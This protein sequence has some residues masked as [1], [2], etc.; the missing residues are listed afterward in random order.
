MAVLSG[1]FDMTEQSERRTPS[2]DECRTFGDES[3]HVD[4]TVNEEGHETEN[5][6]HAEIVSSDE[7]QE[8]GDSEC[9]WIARIE[10]GRVRLLVTT[11]EDDGWAIDQQLT[12]G[13]CAQLANFFFRA[14]VALRLAEVAHL[15]EEVELATLVLDEIK[16]QQTLP[17]DGTDWGREQK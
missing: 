17:L 9:G 6:T 14:S 3:F 11:R 8:R 10:E 12:A 13:T 2:P 15:R 1:A 4:Y 5:Q 7:I 16:R